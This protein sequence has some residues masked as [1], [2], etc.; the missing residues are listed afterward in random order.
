MKPRSMHPRRSLA[1]RSSSLDQCL[2]EPSMA[3]MSPPAFTW[4]YCGDRVSRAGQHLARVLRIDEVAQAVLA[5][6]D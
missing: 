5:Q 6:R 2:A 1:A 4:W 3:A